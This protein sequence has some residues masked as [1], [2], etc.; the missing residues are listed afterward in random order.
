MLLIKVLHYMVYLI[1]MLYVL[2]SKSTSYYDLILA[3]Y[4]FITIHWAVLKGECIL[5]YLEKKMK[6]CDYKLGD[7]PDEDTLNPIMLIIGGLSIATIL[8]ISKKMKLNVPLVAFII[9][10]PRLII[11]FKLDDPLKIRELVAPLL[12]MYVLKDNQYFIPGLL[13]ILIGSCIVKYKDQN[14]CIEPS[15]VRGT[16]S[17]ST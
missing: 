2:L 16:T 1:P 14:S 6:N 4:I 12:G 8:Y 9:I 11:L 7:K 3:G 13:G 10:I 5:N 15:Y 17:E